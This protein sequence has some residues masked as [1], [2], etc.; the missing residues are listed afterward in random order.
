MSHI[1]FTVEAQ[2]PPEANSATEGIS[3]KLYKCILPRVYRALVRLCIPT[4][5]S[6]D[7]GNVPCGLH[8]TE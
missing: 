2:V 8:V 6:N 1:T 5:I 7:L 4:G 3:L